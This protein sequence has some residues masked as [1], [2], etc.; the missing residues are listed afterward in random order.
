MSQYSCL[1]RF[2]YAYINIFLQSRIEQKVTPR[3]DR[4]FFLLVFNDPF[5]N[6]NNFHSLSLFLIDTSRLVE[7]NTK[8]LYETNYNEYVEGVNIIKQLSHR[9]RIWPAGRYF[10][11]SPRS[12]RTFVLLIMINQC[13]CVTKLKV[14]IIMLT[15]TIV[16]VRLSS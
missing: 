8:T 5:T 13:L 2:T 12:T 10:R 6:T 7:R 15:I 14:I 4:S 11:I 1:Y 9:S 16:K 3:S